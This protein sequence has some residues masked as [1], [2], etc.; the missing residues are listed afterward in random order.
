[1]KKLIIKTAIITVCVGL[2]FIGLLLGALSLFAPKTMVKFFDGIGF[3]NFAKQCSERAYE[4]S[5]DIVDLYDLILRLDVSKESQKTVDYVE[6]MFANQKFDEFCALMD[7]DGKITTK[8]YLSVKYVCAL[9]ELNESQKALDFSVQFVL[10]SGYTKYN[11]LR[12]MFNDLFINLDQDFKEK[13]AVAVVEV[14]DTLTI[15][16]QIELINQ[17]IA[18]KS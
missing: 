4:K 7:V 11:P 1:M 14:R 3:D 13:T 15:P 10:D 6:E 5:D 17:D 16:E 18:N 2:A 12:A 8:E 9:V